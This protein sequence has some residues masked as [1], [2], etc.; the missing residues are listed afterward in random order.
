M[1]DQTRGFIDYDNGS[2]VPQDLRG[3]WRMPRRDS[4]LSPFAVGFRLYRAIRCCSECCRCWCSL[5]ARY[6]R[7]ISSDSPGRNVHDRKRSSV[8]DCTWPSDVP[9]F[10]IASHLLTATIQFTRFNEEFDNKNAPR[11]LQTNL[12]NTALFLEFGLACTDYKTVLSSSWL[13]SFFFLPHC[14]WQGFFSSS[15]TRSSF[16][17]FILFTLRPRHTMFTKAQRITLYSL[18]LTASVGQI[19]AGALSASSYEPWWSLVDPA[20]A[21]QGAYRSKFSR[22]AH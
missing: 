5:E 13:A 12:T 22:H 4:S 6:L 10:V 2:A 15:S 14:H 21:P 16:F 19:I 1:T 3:N 8:H 9:I 18:L 7:G 20:K 17:Q 11:W